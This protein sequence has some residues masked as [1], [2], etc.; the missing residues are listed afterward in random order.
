[1]AVNEYSDAI[2]AGLLHRLGGRVTLGLLEVS[3]SRVALH[4]P[5]PPEN[6]V[7]GSYI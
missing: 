6:G 3:V 1:M 7:R 5:P 4:C 2:V